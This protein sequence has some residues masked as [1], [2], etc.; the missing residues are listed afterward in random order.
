VNVI[1]SVV[2]ASIYSRKVHKFE[3]TEVQV[4][5]LPTPSPVAYEMDKLILENVPKNIE[6][7]Y[8][9][10]FIMSCLGIKEDDF[11]ITRSNDKVLLVLSK[12]YSLAGKSLISL[13]L[14]AYARV[15]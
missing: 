14:G 3:Q 15:R 1:I 4:K 12:E 7:E 6:E 5:Y 10:L 11:S 8:L 13:N 9:A 2:A